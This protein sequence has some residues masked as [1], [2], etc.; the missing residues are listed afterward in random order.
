MARSANA[1]TAVDLYAQLCQTHG[2]TAANAWHGIARLLLA[3]NVWREGIGWTEFHNFV[4]YRERND[5]KT[6]KGG[7]PNK[8]MQRAE[9]LTLYLASQLGVP[10]TEISNHIGLYWKLPQISH[11]QPHNLLG[12]A[13]RSLIVTVLETFGDPGVKYQ[14]E[15]A[16]HALFPGYDLITRST[17]AKIDIVARRNGVLVALLSARWRLRHDRIDLVDEARAYAPPARNQNQHCKLYPVIGEFDPKR[18]LKVLTNCPPAMKNAALSEAI[19][20]APQLLWEGIELNGQTSDLRDLEWL[21]GET[22]NW[23]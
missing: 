2:F 6:T 16:P 23:H 17:N 5:Y 22:Y 1:Q 7:K 15:V 8:A 9:A 18:L 20:F 11:Q 3:T 14:E 21:I 13:F 12:H 19:H 4:V 10:R